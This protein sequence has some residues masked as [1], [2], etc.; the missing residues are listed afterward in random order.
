MSAVEL[1]NTSAHG[2]L[3]PSH[4]YTRELIC[5]SR[6]WQDYTEP[7][8]FAIWMA[9]SEVDQKFLGHFATQTSET[10]P[11]LSGMLYKILGLSAILSKKLLRARKLRR[12]DPTRET[13]SFQLYHHILWLSREG[14]I[15]VEQYVHPMVADYVELRVLA[16]KLQASF[17]HIFVL[18]HNQPRVYHRGIQALPGSASFVD[19]VNSTAATDGQKAGNA[20]E[21]STKPASASSHPAEGGPVG[22]GGYLQPPGLEAPAQPKFAASF[23]LPAIDYTP[24]ATE[25]FTYVA[26]L[27]DQLLPGSHPIRLSVKLE[28]A[29]YLYDCLNDSKAC[30]RLAK[31]AIADV[32]NAQEGMDD[33]SFEDAAE[34]VSVLGKMVKRGGKTTSST[35]GSSNGGAGA[36]DKAFSDASQGTPAEAGTTPKSS[37]QQSKQQ[38]PSS[39][40]RA[41]PTTGG[42][43]SNIPAETGLGLAIS[44]TTMA[45][46][47]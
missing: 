32:Y 47:V 20:P 41:I 22:A 13:K 40:Q 39:P 14:L 33:E 19:I 27:A 4:S 16:Y 37:H 29:A 12:L 28:Y 45:N 7:I 3:S 24:R 25:C 23:I 18:F 31:Q 6:L 8:E 9:S 1:L 44:P 2:P 10:N 46:P 11:F 15:I 38:Q 36:G 43:P 34:L 42:T 30:R 5:A 26:A 21:S 35:G 17:Y